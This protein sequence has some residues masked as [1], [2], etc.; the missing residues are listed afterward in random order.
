[1]DRTRRAALNADP[2]QVHKIVSQL[3]S[4]VIKFNRER[5]PRI[6]IRTSL[7]RDGR[8]TITV[9]D[10]GV[11][12]RA[13]VVERVTEPFFQAD[14]GMA[15]QHGGSGLGLTLVKAMVAAMGGELA[16][17]SRPRR[18][19]LVTVTFGADRTVRLR[20]RSKVRVSD[21]SVRAAA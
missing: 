16:I 15:R 19:T 12:M 6:V 9:A 13:D 21:G 2:R 18:G 5:D 7:D 11:G 8:M 1:V 20:R 4:N 17:R 14:V 10:T 3:L